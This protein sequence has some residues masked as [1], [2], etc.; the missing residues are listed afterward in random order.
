MFNNIKFLS[1]EEV[2]NKTIFVNGMISAEGEYMILR[3]SGI[4]SKKLTRIVKKY[5]HIKTLNG[6]NKVVKHLSKLKS[7]DN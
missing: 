5:I 2:S 6:K 1:L 3:T 7:R 4:C